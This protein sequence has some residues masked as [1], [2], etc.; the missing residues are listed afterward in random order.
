M[1]EGWLR[2]LKGQEI[3]VYSAGITSHGLNPLAVQVMK[4]AG[5]DIS[6][7]TSKCLSELASITFDV[8]V[9]V[10]DNAHEN[11]HIFSGRTTVIHHSF[12]D[13]PRLT[14]G[15][16]ESE[17]LPVYRRVRDEIR[18]FIQDTHWIQSRFLKV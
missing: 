15:L 6:N 12:D 1:A 11:C 16:S 10:C 17:A 7:Q 18:Q 4:E 2:A 5:I 3:D 8:V 14:N 13:P 9:T